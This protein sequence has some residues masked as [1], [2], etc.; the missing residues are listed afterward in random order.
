MS[1]MP[2]EVST[3]TLP[4]MEIAGASACAVWQPALSA[5]LDGEL[6]LGASGALIRHLEK[7]PEC[8][9]RLEQYRVLGQRLRTLPSPLVP[10]DL[11]LRLRVRASHYAVRGLR[12]QY[13]RI[14]LSSAV[15]ALALPTAVGTIAAL[16]MFAALVGGVH[17][18]VSGN[19][20]LPDPSVGVDAQP[21]RLT[22]APNF[23][24]SGPLLLEAQIDSTG[25][26]YGYSVLSGALNPS[27]ISRINNQ[28]L[29]SV[30]QPATT[31]FGQPTNGSLLVS[32]GTVDVRG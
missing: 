2:P 30:F 16:C 24:I 5:Y 11:G 1:K 20:L 14:R 4:A 15:Q 27:L 19:P 32:F 6:D 17:S 10:A 9:G 31:N 12:W 25:H 28:L 3:S 23:D 21:P 26:V 7:C 29:M 13:W 18:N 8:S 22:S